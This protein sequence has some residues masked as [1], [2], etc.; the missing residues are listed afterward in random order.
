VTARGIRRLATLFV[1][2]FG[3]LAAA[4]IVVQVILG[5]RLEASRFNPLRPPPA[6]GRGTIVARD[7][8]ILAESVGDRRV[9]PHGGLLAQSVGYVSQRYGESGLEATFDRFLRPPATQA[10]PLSQ[11]RSIFEPGRR[12]PQGARLV[13]TIDLPTQETLYAD[14]SRYARAAGVVLDPDT[15]EVLA[16]ASVPSF[17]PNRLNATFA[18]LASDPAS[19]LLDRATYGLYPPGSTF[20]IFTAATALE[21]G[22]VT[23]QT[24]FV[25][26]GSLR[27]GNFTVHDNEGE[28]TGKRTLTGAFALSSN[29]DFARI[30]LAIGADRWFDAA[31]SWRLGDPIP[32]DIPT[33]RAH[34]P[35]RNEMTPGIL[36][37]LGFGQA[38]LLVT[39]LEMALIG[40]TVASGGTMP[41]PILVREIDM[42]PSATRGSG[43]FAAERKLITPHERLAQPISPDVAAEVTRLMLAVVERGTGTAA[44]LPGVAVAGKTGTATNPFGRAH[45]WFVAFAPA[46]APRV[47]LAIVVENAGYGGAVSAP[48]ARDVLRVALGRER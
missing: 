40:S 2:L 15:G 47:A 12:P 30:A 9:Y 34:L 5:P 43:S 6:E 37:Q 20:K 41:R 27:V 25:D 19:P 14:L 33:E 17:D 29:V 39:P 10:N 18:Q 46:Q 24:T 23:P 32:F 38:D 36:A 11:L 48:I 42:N 3:I 44:A 13:T 16:L 22:V 7:G 26:N 31:A 21:D 28:A 45:A 4:Q 35:R 8:E 1:V